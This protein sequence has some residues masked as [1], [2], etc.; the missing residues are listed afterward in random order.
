MPGYVSLINPP[1]Q[2]PTHPP[3]YPKQ[4]VISAFFDEKGLVRQQLDSFDS[5]LEVGLQ[6]CVDG[7][8]HP[9]THNHP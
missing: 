9:P 1:T 4:V 2:P 7:T 5:F 3:T 8:Y 6:E